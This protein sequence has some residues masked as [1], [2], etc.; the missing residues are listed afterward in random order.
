LLGGKYRS[1]RLIEDRFQ[2][3]NTKDTLPPG[4]DM[5]EEERKRKIRRKCVG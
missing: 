4:L 3:E 2:L 1:N 5:D